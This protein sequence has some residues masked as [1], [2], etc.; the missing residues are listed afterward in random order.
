VRDGVGFYT[1]RILAPYLNEAAWLVSEGVAI[2]AIDRALVKWGFPVGPITLLD[3]V[4]VD[5][6]SKVGP[7]LLE[8]FGDRMRAPGTTETLIRDGRLG[9]KAKKG[10]Y[11]YD[12]D[13]KGNRPVD[14]AVYDVIG[15]HPGTRIDDAEIAER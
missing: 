5:V 7:F 14:T 15:V 2:D 1:S 3:E 6:A 4:G 12:K 13:Y 10:F 9:R 8:A 11:R